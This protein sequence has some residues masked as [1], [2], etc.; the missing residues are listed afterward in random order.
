M[1]PYTKQL[2]TENEELRNRLAKLEGYKNILL[3]RITNEWHDRDYV[4][5][6]AVFS[7][8]VEFVEQEWN[9]KVDLHSEEEIFAASSDKERE[10]YITENKE[11]LELFELY[12][13]WVQDHPGCEIGRAHV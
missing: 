1:D 3:P 13:W 10:L 2:E 6:H 9:G 7:V 12:R 5:M 4:L 8:L 11:K